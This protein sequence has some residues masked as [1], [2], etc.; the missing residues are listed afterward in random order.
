MNLLFVL[1][2]AFLVLGFAYVAASNYDFTA[3]EFKAE[4]S[5]AFRPPYYFE[6]NSIASEFNAFFF[7]FLFSLLFFGLTAP[8]ALAIEGA[9]Y[10]TLISM[11]SPQTFDFAFAI[12]QVLAAYSAVLLGQAVLND[13]GSEK[14]VFDAWGIALKY[15]AAG[16]LL[17]AALVASKAFLGL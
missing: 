13:I 7:V 15:F 10:G 1:S 17:T 12:P 4:P 8:V 14:S 11:P 2:V 9:K 6:E 3:G 5:I 16:I